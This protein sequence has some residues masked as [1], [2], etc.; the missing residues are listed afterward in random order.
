MWRSIGRD[1]TR[2]PIGLAS[3]LMLAAGGAR[4]CAAQDVAPQGNSASA[5]AK[6]QPAKKQSADT[7]TKAKKQ[8][9]DTSIKIEIYG[10][11]QGDMINDFKTN[12]PDWFD[13]NRPSR[14]PAF[15]DE[16]GH[17]GHTWLSARQSRFGTKAGAGPTTAIAAARS[18]AR[19]RSRS[20]MA[21]ASRSASARSVRPIVSFTRRP[22]GGDPNRRRRSS[23][24]S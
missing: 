19:A 3:L 11:T 20:A 9:V 22:N 2:R 17:N 5:P 23:S 13:V 8:Q 16:F 21:M 14:L 1:F 10:F 6:K 18:A 4:I 12:N 15:E 7:S 24:A